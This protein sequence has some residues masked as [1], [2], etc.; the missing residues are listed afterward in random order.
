MV[1]PQQEPREQASNLVPLV[2][3]LITV[4]TQATT[5]LSLLP[6]NAST[7][8]NRRFLSTYLVECQGWTVNMPRPMAPSFPPAMGP[9]P[10]HWQ[11][12]CKSVVL[13]SQ[14]K[15]LKV[16]LINTSDQ[17]FDLISTSSS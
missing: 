8:Q 11:G 5:H 9:W 10:V 12:A 4:P 7:T 16:V 1:G 17:K 15:L 13:T 2:P 6:S 3:H 14:W